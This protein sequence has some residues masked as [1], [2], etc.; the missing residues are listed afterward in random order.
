MFYRLSI[1]PITKLFE[2][3]YFDLIGNEPQGF[4][5]SKRIRYIIYKAIVW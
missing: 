2:K 5:G 4:K 3:V 1:D